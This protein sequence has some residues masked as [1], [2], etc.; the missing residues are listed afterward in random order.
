MGILNFF[1][2]RKNLATRGI[3]VVSQRASESLIDQAWRDNEALRVEETPKDTSVDV[4]LKQMS[5]EDF[6]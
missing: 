1:E 4:S 3:P 5:P 6:K 2:W